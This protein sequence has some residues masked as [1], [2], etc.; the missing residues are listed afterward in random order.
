MQNFLHPPFLAV[1]FCAVFA[2]FLQ[3]RR[4][5]GQNKAKTRPKQ[6]QNKAKTRPKQGQNKAKTRPKQGQNKAKTRS[7]QG[8]NKAKTAP[9]QRKRMKNGLYRKFLRGFLWL[10]SFKR[11]AFWRKGRNFATG[12][13]K[14]GGIGLGRTIL[15][16][17][18]SAVHK[19]FL[20]S[21]VK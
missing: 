7:K 5:Q 4:K 14:K 19:I 16:K 21:V 9:K 10:F 11:Q 17:L 1:R 12:G 8:Q 3:R 18:F 6:G 15:R 13:K 20:I 2:K